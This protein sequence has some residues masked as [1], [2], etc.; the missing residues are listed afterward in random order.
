MCGFVGFASRIPIQ[1]RERLV[2]MNRSIVHRGPDGEGLALW[3]T[4]G[5]LMVGDER[6]VS[7][8]GHRRL[9]IIDLSSAGAQPMS[10]EDGTLWIAYNGEFYNFAD[11]RKELEEAGHTFRSHCDTETILHLCEQHGIAGTLNRMNGMFAF[12]IW[13]TRERELILARDRVGK[14]PLYY[15]TASDGTL[16]FASELKALE[17]AGLVN[18]DDIDPVAFAQFWQYGYIFGER[19]IYT[20]IKKLLPGH[21]AIWQDGC[22]QI[23]QYWDCPFGVGELR[24]ES[25][26]TLTDELEAILSDAIRLRLVADVPLGL[27]L[28]G[29]I[30]SSLIAA[31]TARVAGRGL[32]TFSVAFREAGFNEVPYAQAIAK[33]LGMSNEPLDVTD[34]LRRSFEAIFQQFDEPFGDSSAIPTW[35]LCKH[36]RERVTVA[37]SGDGG[38]ELFGGYPYYQ[39]ALR[40][41]GG[42]EF[43][44]LS[45]DGLPI[46]SRLWE[47]YMRL[48]AK[49]DWPRYWT[50]ALG[51]RRR[52][53]LL[54]DSF[55]TVA[56][57]DAVY[58]DR[59]MHLHAV[60][61]ADQLSQM[62]YLDLKLYLPDDILAKVDRTSMAHA[63]EC[64][65]PLLDHRVIEF[66]ARLPFHA[67]IGPDGRGKRILRDLLARH[68]PRELFERPKQGFSIPWNQ[69]CTG[70]AATEM[71]TQW[72]QLQLPWFRPESGGRLFP[73]DRLGHPLLQAYAFATMV[74]F[75]KCLP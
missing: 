50:R 44:S 37:L 46:K 35:F 18:R 11:Y 8:L 7:G 15:T 65:S 38:D 6:V 32:K 69:W 16:H 19:T 9:S 5:R 42:R 68:V 55:E 22:F 49:G 25:L 28:S 10:N 75:K 66:A 72:D 24:T 13:N 39:Q 21:Y 14:K 70:P 60:K 64:R 34:D 45:A 23:R 57:S 27:F 63:L 73:K 48:G 3:D 43:R 1:A 41:W 30:D 29:G 52:R 2:A 59:M 61:G 51:D 74:F 31:L 47:A 62:Q 71:R 53:M 58:D 20:N 17:V 4:A 26:S 36:A 12:A 56:T 33:H 54:S 67:K 40:I